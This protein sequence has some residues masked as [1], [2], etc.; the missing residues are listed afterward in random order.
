M[1]KLK[2]S[3]K[4][5][6]SR[7][8]PIGSKPKAG[9][10]TGDDSKKDE[11]TRQSKILPLLNKLQSTIPNDRTMALG[12]IT[13]LCEDERMRKLLLKEKLI[14][15]IMEQCLNDSNDE[16]VVESFGLLRNLGIEEGYDVLKYYWRSGIWTSIEA[17]LGKIEKSF[18]Y[19]IE[20]PHNAANKKHHD[21]SK[22]QLLYDFTEN[23]L[24]LIVALSDGSEDLSEAV[25]EKID[26]VS[27]LVIKLLTQT[28][29]K[30]SIAMYN[31]L[32]EFIYDLSTESI[33][34]IQQINN[35]PEF[36]L[37]SISQFLEKN[38]SF[39]R[40]TKVYL[41][42]IKFNLLEVIGQPTNK[43]HELSQELL[44]T[45]FNLIVG[46]DIEDLKT[47]LKTIQEPDNSQPIQKGDGNIIETDLSKDQDLKKQLKVDL[48]SLE[49]SLDLVTSIIEYLSINEENIEEQIHLS[50]G[51]IEILLD[52]IYPSIIE[53]I[54]FELTNDFILSFIEKLLVSLN[55]LSWLML[56][57][58]ELPVEWYEK[59][60]Q[61]WD[62]A[63]AVSSKASDVNLQKNCLN[64]F[65]SVS[66][67]LGPQVQTKIQDGMIDELLTKGELIIT[68]KDE[69]TNEDWEFLLATV[70]L[71]GNLAPVIGNSEKTFKISE[72]LLGSTELFIGGEYKSATNQGIIID[73]VNESINLIFDIFGDKD[74]DYDNEI[75]VQKNYLARLKIIEQK[76][77]EFTKKVDK[78]KYPTLKVKGNET[79]MNLGR[80]I[81]YKAS[82]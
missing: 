18:E 33:D 52:K 32:L 57:N 65:W 13:I 39:N 35:I 69:S 37:D 29:F 16:I 19:L 25:F 38:G 1:G 4:N 64:V 82:E 14:S 59:S 70:G 12:A 50:H 34:F 41:I 79:L 60:L 9:K 21:K 17:S 55:N 44:S 43:K 66:K 31:A 40:L 76:F 73:I 54:K 30:F 28:Q 74:Y 3:K 15:I 24:S 51:L 78:N 56:S 36:N 48:S 42:G 8:N 20:N 61:L 80:F 23:I 49:V 26:P 58:E 5:N 53:L 72:F 7:L 75:F 47:K 67:A 45:I 6:R 68:K 2:R 63:S 22:I 11:S 77:R 62:I 71:L 10:S 46:I 81:Q 27:K